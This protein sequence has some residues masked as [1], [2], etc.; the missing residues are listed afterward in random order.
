LAGIEVRSHMKSY[1]Y[2]TKYMFDKKVP[3]AEAAAG[4]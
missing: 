2:P 1:K 3:G 4:G